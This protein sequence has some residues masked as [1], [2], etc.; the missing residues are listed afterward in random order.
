MFR[1][2]QDTDQSEFGFGYRAFTF[3][4]RPFQVASSTYF[5]YDSMCSVLQPQKAS[6]LVWAIPVSLAAT[7][8]IDFS[9]SSCR[10]LDVSVL[11]VYLY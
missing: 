8:G 5:I 2:T 9:F 11:C 6:F 1:R 4:G 10:Y 3:F 7:Q